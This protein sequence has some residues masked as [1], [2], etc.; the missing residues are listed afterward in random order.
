MLLSKTSARLVLAS[1][2]PRRSQL[3]SNLG[4]DFTVVASQVDETIE[5][6]LS[7]EQA[8]I[9]IARRKA[10][11]VQRKLSLEAKTNPEQETV[12]V[13]AD[14]IVVIEGKLLGKPV[15]AHEAIAMLSSLSGKEHKVYTGLALIVFENGH[16]QVPLTRSV[17]SK[18][19]FRKL[20]R[21]EIKAY[22]LSGEPMDKAG[23]YALQGKA[24]VFVQSIEGC[25]TNI[26][27]LPMP[28]LVAMLRGVGVKVLGC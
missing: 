6:G 7:P 15:S 2:S 13:A 17:V 1:A 23:A 26:I 4:L 22:V 3:L 18:V 10:Q 20:E 24:S 11:A 16:A 12:I 14:T 8:V 21:A 19:R 27:G 5:P 25:Y 28:D 9:E